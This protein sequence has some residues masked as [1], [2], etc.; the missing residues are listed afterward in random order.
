MSAMYL[1]PTELRLVRHETNSQT[2]Y[3]FHKIWANA[4]VGLPHYKFMTVRDAINWAD[5][6]YP[7]VGVAMGGNKK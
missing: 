3:T 4:A 2:F 1:K 5:R 6:E 7:G